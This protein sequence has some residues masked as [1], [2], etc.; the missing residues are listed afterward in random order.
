MA[1]IN[2][3]EE[4]RE[5]MRRCPDHEMTVESDEDWHCLTCEA[6]D[7]QGDGEVP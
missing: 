2:R 5:H 7:D 6:E 1:E 4:V 3:D